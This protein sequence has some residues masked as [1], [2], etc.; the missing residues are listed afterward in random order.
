MTD[1]TTLRVLRIS[2]NSTD[3]FRLDLEGELRQIREGLSQSA[4]RSRSRVEVAENI[5]VSQIGRELDAV[6]PQ[7]L[8]V[9]GHGQAG[10]LVARGDD[11]QTATVPHSAL[12]EPLRHRK[13]E[14]PLVVLSECES[15][16]LVRHLLDAGASCVVSSDG[17]IPNPVMFAFTAAFYRAIGDGHTVRTAFEQ[18]QAAAGALPNANEEVKKLRLSEKDAAADW[19]S[20]ELDAALPAHHRRVLLWA[21]LDAV[22]PK[23][24]EMMALMFPSTAP[25][26]PVRLTSHGATPLRRDTGGAVSGWTG[27]GPALDRA[28]AEVRESGQ[29]EGECPVYVGGNAPMAV[30][31]MIGL[32][33]GPWAKSV[34]ALQQ[35]RD[36]PAQR[37]AMQAPTRSR[38]P[39]LFFDR[40]E[41]LSSPSRARGPVSLYVS[42]A[43][44]EESAPL[45]D[46]MRAHYPAQ[47]GCVTLSTRAR[48]T[49]STRNIGQVMLELRKHLQDL[50][51]QYGGATGLVIAVNGAWPL[52]LAVGQC[53]NHKQ[54][55]FIEAVNFEGGA[56]RKALRFGEEEQAPPPPLS[57]EP[58]DQLARAKV[59]SALREAV[60]S[61][62]RELEPEALRVPAGLMLDERAAE[63]VLAEL[64]SNLSGL[65]V[66][67]KPGEGGFQMSVD[68]GELSFGAALLEA[69]RGV[70]EAQLVILGP[71]FVLHELYHV[72]QRLG[73]A[74]YRG[75]GRAGFVLEE[76]DFWADA[77]ALYNV[78]AHRIREGGRSAE[79]DPASP[80]VAAIDAHIAAMEAFDR[81]ESGDKLHQLPERRLRRY[82]IWHLQR[83]RARTLRT[84]DAL[85]ALYDERL[86]VELAPLKGFINPEQDKVVEGADSSTQL[87]AA[88]S[89]RLIRRPNLPQNFNPA[90]L[91]DAV[92]CFDHAK[93]REAMD[94]LVEAERELLVPRS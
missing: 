60:E 57:A 23:E 89:G 44:D 54:F 24:E 46:Y 63:A 67:N 53:I 62:R 38:T 66:Q 80:A 78:S 39:E 59:L 21:D 68:R 16:G 35:P 5:A 18:G 83:C 19:L 27:I 8:H 85:R 94:Y 56:Y 43:G 76:V 91:V 47:A 40:V 22:Q 50:R 88:L 72:A 31:L 58:A 14:T 61:F 77:F 65:R 6:D 71:L 4:M 29:R 12:S 25:V 42:L 75:V 34:F 90:A 17:R 10:K 36:Y 70:D 73:G 30:F 26:H 45:D 41:G 69:L 1:D 11:D 3:N 86:L 49:L 13:G 52:A 82:L 9:S 81:M 55:S 84:P 64:R 15:S 51:A 28:A 48:R 2:W 20:F 37:F 74:G 33:L 7:I 93:L 32:H 79:R 92:R 87:F